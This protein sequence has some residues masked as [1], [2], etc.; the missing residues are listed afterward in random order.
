MTE[1]QKK[2]ADSRAP[3]GSEAESE[4]SDLDA[5]LQEYEKDG[6]K[7]R[8]DRTLRAVKPIIDF[9]RSEMA[10]SQTNALKQDLDNACSFLKEAET[11]SEIDNKLLIGFMEAYAQDNAKFRKAFEKRSEDPDVWQAQL[12]KGREWLEGTIK[13]TFKT[14]TSDVEAAKAAVKGQSEKAEAKGPD[15]NEM[16]NMSGVKWQQFLDSEI[17]KA[18]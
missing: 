2:T 18:G 1:Q 16:L 10:K 12:E 6:N 13:E 15:T 9:A 17:A 11:L 7:P 3:A 8:P 5:L 14:K 4:T